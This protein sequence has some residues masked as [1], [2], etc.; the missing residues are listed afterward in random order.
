ME[1]LNKS[2]DRLSEA[3]E[4][5]RK[6]LDKASDDFNTKWGAFLENFVEK[7]LPR[8]FQKRGIPVHNTAMR[9][10]RC[11][12]H[13]FDTEYDLVVRSRECVV[14]ETRTTMTNAPDFVPKTY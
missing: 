5:T 14:V 1:A 11:K 13:S 6:N 10:R 7:N 12:D 9:M 4:R 3:Q 2:I 8:L